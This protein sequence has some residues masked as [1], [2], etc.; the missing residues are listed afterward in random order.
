M[1]VVG[2]TAAHWPI[3]NSWGT[4]WGDNGLAIVNDSF[5]RQARDLWAVD[6]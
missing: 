2:Y 3:V 1:V 6:V 4:G 5:M